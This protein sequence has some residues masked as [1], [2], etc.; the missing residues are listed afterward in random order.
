MSLQEQIQA[1]LKQAMKDRDRDRMSALRML[2]SSLKNEAIEKGRG[3]QGDL[4]DEEVQK[5]LATE[6]KRRDESVASYRDAGRDEQADKEQAESDLI[7]GYLPAQ[8]TDDELAE[9][10]DTVMAQVDAQGPQDMGAVMKNVMAEVGNRADGAR[11]STEVKD[12]LQALTG[13]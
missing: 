13:G 3:P 4:S 5:V 6:K 12:R 7:A 9:V 8:L 2:L 1:D 10:I 11:V